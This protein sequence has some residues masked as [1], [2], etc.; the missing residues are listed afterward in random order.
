MEQLHFL[1]AWLAAVGAVVLVVASVLTATGRTPSY[2]LLDR[3]ILGQIATLLAAIISGLIVAPA[4]SGP[5][6]AL[7]FLYAV[8]A[9]LAPGATRYA[10][11]ASDATRMGRWVTVAALVAAGAVARLFMTGR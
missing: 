1:L 11:R 7:H 9:L 2:L 6:D 8:V 10:L 3:A 4:T 5:R